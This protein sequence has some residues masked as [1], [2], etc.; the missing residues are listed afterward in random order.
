MFFALVALF[1]L[2]FFFIFSLIL[3][4]FLFLMFFI[5][6][7]NNFILFSFFL[8]LLPFIL[9]HVAER[10]LVL[11]AGVRSVSLRW[12]SH[13]QDIDPSETSWLHVISNGESSPRDLHL[14]AK[15]QFHSTTSTLQCW[16]PYA[17]Q[18]ARQENNPT[19]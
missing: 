19:H 3:L 13:V 16:T 9:S 7:F 12:E 14:N 15:M 6:Y 11:Q 5:L 17:K 1:F 10:V 4:I 8:S 2:S 18:V